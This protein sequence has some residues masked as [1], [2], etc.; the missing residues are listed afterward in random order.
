MVAANIR[1]FGEK[2]KQLYVIGLADKELFKKTI[3]GIKK[4]LDDYCLVTAWDALHDPKAREQV[5]GC[6]AA[7]LIEQKGLSSYS[8]MKEEIIF[9]VNSG[10]E[11]IG[12]V[13][14]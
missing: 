12:I 10:K 14:V 9:L 3:D 1:A 13:I 11:I 2:K 5:V 7:I 6:D 8:D 4:Y